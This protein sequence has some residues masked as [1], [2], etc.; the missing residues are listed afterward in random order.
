[1]QT[2]INFIKHIDIV[3]K[4]ANSILAFIWW[5]L[6]SCQ[7][8]I[9]ADVYLMYV[10][11]ILEYAVVVWAPHTKC[12]IEAV[13]QRATRFVMSDYNHISSATVMLL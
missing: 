3:C 12:D 11:P 6:K 1:M 8:Q 7:R 2:F 4:T 10:R 9:K 13:Q 5:N